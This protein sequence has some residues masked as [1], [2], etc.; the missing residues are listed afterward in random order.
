MIRAMVHYRQVG[1]NYFVPEHELRGEVARCRECNSR[2]LW[3]VTGSGARMPL[4]VETAE[5]GDNGDLRCVSHFATCPKAARF[6]S[7]PSKP[8]TACPVDACSGTVRHG[9]LLCSTCWKLVPKRL[10]DEVWRTWKACE[11]GAPREAWK[12]YETAARAALT[13][14][15]ASKSSRSVR[16]T[17]AF[18]NNQFDPG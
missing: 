3:I 8:K 12:V 13:A 11:G 18:G 16:Q 1:T 2:V 5:P 14:A 6:R 15:K 10:R 17:E 9:E 4:D 7:K